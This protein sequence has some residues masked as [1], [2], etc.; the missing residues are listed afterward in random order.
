MKNLLNCPWL[1]CLVAS[2]G[3][4]PVVYRSVATGPVDNQFYV[5]ADDGGNNKRVLL[6]SDDGARAVCKRVNVTGVKD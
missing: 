6:C 5:T 1:L 2:S 4:T 3:C